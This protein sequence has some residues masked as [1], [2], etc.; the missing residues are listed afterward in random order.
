MKLVLTL[1]LQRLKT[2]EDFGHQKFTLLLTDKFL[3]GLQGDVED[4][5]Q[6]QSAESSLP[7]KLQRAIAAFRVA[8][9]DF[10]DA[11]KE[12]N[13]NAV[14]KYLTSMDKAREK[15]WRLA[16]KYLKIMAS[17][18][19]ASVAKIANEG[20]FIF[21]KYSDPTKLSQT[22]AN[23]IFHNLLQ[24]IEKMG[25]TKRQKINF[26]P[27]YE[28][29]K[30]NDDAFLE[31]DQQ[32]TNEEKNR[33]VGI[34][35]NMRKAADD[36]YDELVKSINIAVQIDE[37][38]DYTDYVNSLNVGIERQM[39]TLKGRATRRKNSL[40]EEDNDRLTVE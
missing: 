31:A 17:H 18:P 34:V 9:N 36:A 22:E 23:G 29:M 20:V 6:V 21:E 40:A 26:D 32:R 10:D 24:D 33:R 16:K 13:K 3:S 37:E 1:N 35:Q 2:Q 12:P 19:D 30:E 8:F 14:T 4:G 15:S 25:T 39:T 11:L 7:P 5:P 27:W 38:T 28:S